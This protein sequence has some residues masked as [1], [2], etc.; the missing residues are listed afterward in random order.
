ML[1]VSGTFRIEP[2]RFVDA[3]PAMRRMIEASVAEDGCLHYSYA[4]DMLAPN[5]IR[6]HELWRDRAALD[7]HFASA[8]IA[9]WRAAWPELGIGE[10]QLM[11]YTLEAGVDI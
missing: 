11:L 1:L 2:D 6:V 5:F 4:Q 10:R 8:H 3:L 7:R 9:E